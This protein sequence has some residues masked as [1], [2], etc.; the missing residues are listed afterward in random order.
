MAKSN[1]DRLDEAVVAVVEAAGAITDGTLTT[2][3]IGF[4]ASGQY[5]YQV[6]VLELQYPLVGVGRGQPSSDLR[7]NPEGDVAEPRKA[8]DN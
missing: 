7:E 5:P 4:Q 3:T 6:E 2:I 8:G 1:E